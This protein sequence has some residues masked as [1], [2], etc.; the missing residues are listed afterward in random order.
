MLNPVTDL[1]AHVK[2]VCA[3]ASA[4][5]AVPAILTAGGNG[6][7]TKITG[8]YFD[9]AGYDS[10]VL[11]IAAFANLTNTKLLTF[12][13]EMVESDDHSTWSSPAEVV[14]AATTL[15]IA[16]S[17]TVFWGSTQIAVDLKSRKKYVRFDITPNLDA[18]G[19]D[20]ALWTAV[21]VLGGAQ[22]LPAV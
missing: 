20:T 11:A 8:Q 16:T 12:A 3:G 19:T 2:C 1:D 6:D 18:S 9:R 17:S 15:L 22:I 13:V 10:M 4:Y 21:G 5:G 14:Q 7:N